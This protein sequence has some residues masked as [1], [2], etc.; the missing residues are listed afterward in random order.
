MLFFLYLL[1]IRA[2]NGDL[3]MLI[4]SGTDTRVKHHTNFLKCAQM[5][6]LRERSGAVC[7]RTILVNLRK[8]TVATPRPGR[9]CFA[10]YAPKCDLHSNCAG[11]YAQTLHAPKPS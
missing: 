1:G 5:D 7:N 8:I 10:V 4:S 9:R 6:S 3:W 11:F 2:R